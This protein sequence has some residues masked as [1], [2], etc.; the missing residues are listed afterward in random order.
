MHSPV[1]LMTVII[2]C[3]RGIH[4]IMAVGR[5]LVYLSPSQSTTLLSPILDQTHRDRLS[6]GFVIYGPLCKK[7]LGTQHSLSSD[8]GS[9]L[10]SMEMW[11]VCYCEEAYLHCAVELSAVATACLFV[12]ALKF[13]FACRAAGF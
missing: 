10:P 1:W 5:L 8:I 11:V 12:L 9:M 7:G 13:I 3:C 4:C 2:L 6:T